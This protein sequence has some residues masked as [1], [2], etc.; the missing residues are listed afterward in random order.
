M[1]SPY[2]SNGDRFFGVV[3]RFRASSIKRNM[4]SRTD[5]PAANPDRESNVKMVL[6]V[7]YIDN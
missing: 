4:N 3:V 5:H 6:L 7:D 1:P 2:S